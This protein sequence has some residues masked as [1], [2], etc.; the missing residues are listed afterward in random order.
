MSTPSSRTKAIMAM[1]FGPRS[2]I[3]E[4]SAFI[5]KTVAE[6][7]PLPEPPLP[8]EREPCYRDDDCAMFSCLRC[9]GTGWV[10]RGTM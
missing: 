7:K 4:Q 5:E 1:K 8:L 10:Q 6:R 9:H 2:Y 3:D